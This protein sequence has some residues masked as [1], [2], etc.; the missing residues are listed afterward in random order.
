VSIR[1]EEYQVSRSEMMLLAAREYVRIFW[2]YI[3]ITP[4]FGVLALIFGGGPLQLIGMIA[5]LWPFSIPARAVISSS[6]ASRL[7]SRGCHMEADDKEAIFYGVQANPKRLR[8]R[9]SYNDIR[10]VGRL[11]DLVVLRTRML[12]AVPI[13]IGAFSSESQA[14]SFID[15]VEA[16]IGK[17]LTS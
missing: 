3:L 2:W 12:G 1:T 6:K 16:A 9:L 4:I 14:E 10:S 17:R 13:R 8:F 5:I 11:Q 15:L 7:F